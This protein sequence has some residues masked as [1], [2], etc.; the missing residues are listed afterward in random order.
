MR[1]K[2]GSISSSTVF[3]LISDIFFSKKV[4]KLINCRLHIANKKC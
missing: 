3:L 4:Q 1:P 2:A